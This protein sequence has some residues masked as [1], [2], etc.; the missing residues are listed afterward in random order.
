VGV[1]L[2]VLVCALDRDVDAGRDDDHA[3][4][5]PP[6]AGDA[7]TA[8]DKGRGG[9]HGPQSLSGHCLW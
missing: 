5:K 6:G 7:V 9:W 8:F 2:V 3:A 1:E 4:G